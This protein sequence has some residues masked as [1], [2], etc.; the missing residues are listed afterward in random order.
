MRYRTLKPDG[1]ADPPGLMP[2][3]LSLQ[4]NRRCH[5]TG[6]GRFR[7]RNMDFQVRGYCKETGEQH[8]KTFVQFLKRTSQSR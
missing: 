1:V 3:T 6:Y 8:G 2:N 7:S 4:G 5:Y